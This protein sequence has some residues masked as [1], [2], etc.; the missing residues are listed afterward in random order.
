MGVSE[1]LMIIKKG[2]KYLIVAKSK[3]NIFLIEIGIFV[4]IF[5]CYYLVLIRKRSEDV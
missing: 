2:E 4:K 5:Y 3:I 1:L